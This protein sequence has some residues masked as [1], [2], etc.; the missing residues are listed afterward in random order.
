MLTNQSP[1][2]ICKDTI[3]L[4]CSS[5]VAS[6]RAFL[7]R[8]NAGWDTTPRG[9]P[10]NGGSRWR[11]RRQQQQQQQLQRGRNRRR[12][13][14][15][16]LCLAG[17]DEEL[18]DSEEE[19]V[20]SE[21]R[22]RRRDEEEEEDSPWDTDD[23]AA[24][25]P[26]CM[27][28]LWPSVDGRGRPL[29]HAHSWEDAFG[30]ARTGRLHSTLRTVS[31]PW[32]GHGRLRPRPMTAVDAVRRHNLALVPGPATRSLALDLCMLMCAVSSSWRCLLPG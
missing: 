9:E 13:V 12:A 3:L 25:A 16:S 29:T 23:E 19:E 21:R 6:P 7:E 26:G 8:W 28:F 32:R 24:M 14:S 22:R 30:I 27:A 2:C 5:S 1:A 4:T 31:Q 20:E 17:S 10:A 11:A 18:S 15:D